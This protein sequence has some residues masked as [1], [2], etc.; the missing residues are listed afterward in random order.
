VAE[1]TTPPPRVKPLLRG[2]SHE[3]AALAAAPAALA[4]V[5]SAES[6]AA[7]LGAATYGASLF[8]LFLVSAVYHRRTWSQRARLVAGRLDNAAIFVLIAGTS[9]P[10]C[11][12]VEGGTAHAVLAVVWAGA[13]A[14][15]V[16][17]VAWPRAP[18]PL[19]AAIYVLL[20]WT[21][22]PAAADLRAA[23][24]ADA[25]LLLL[26]GGVAYTTGAVIYALRRPDPFPRVFGYHE[27]FHVLVIAGAACHFV[28]VRD[29][30]RQLG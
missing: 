15:I 24:D 21:F 1:P 13:L 10:L 7:R 2:V 9:T 26:L 14:G 29:A 16:L 4:L 6:S 5:V 8:A 30:V 3:I 17:T 20:G 22:L 25:A 11:L 27:I 23:L 19:M 18:K 12:L 28:V